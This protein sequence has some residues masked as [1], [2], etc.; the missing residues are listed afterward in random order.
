MAGKKAVWLVGVAVVATGM[1][2]SVASA[3]PACSA[4][5][6]QDVAVTRTG[7][8]P[9]MGNVRGT[10]G[11]DR[12]AQLTLETS[13]FEV[14]R[15]IA[16]TGEVEI[17]IA[18]KGEPTIVIRV[19][20]SEG[21]IVTRGS[22]VV[23]GSADAAALRG[24]FTGRAATAFRAHVGEFERRL[25]G[26][27]PAAR[28]DDAHA[29]GFLLAGAFVSS[30][31]GDPTAMGRA[32]DLIIRRIRGRVLAAAFQFRDC[33]SDYERSLLQN[34]SGRSSCL[35]SANEQD[36]WYARAAQRVLC[37]GEFMAST[38]SAEGQFVSC[39]ALLPLMRAA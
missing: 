37:E 28:A 10:L 24:L 27:E 25:I 2:T 8:I 9:G 36:A 11:W 15:T 35:D 21:M 12:R 3:E 20:G 34:D 4:A 39:S 5:L 32:R 19:G 14:G 33:V 22:H 13:D 26:V 16:P 1:R 38:L 17:S 30:L 6:R 29:Y 31:A 18:G 7:K 23:R